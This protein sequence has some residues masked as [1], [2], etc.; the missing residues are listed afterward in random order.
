MVCRT[1]TS[2]DRQVHCKK[3]SPELEGMDIVASASHMNDLTKQFMSMHKNPSPV[4]VGSS[5]KF[6]L[7]RRFSLCEHEQALDNKRWCVHAR[8]RLQCRQGHKQVS[9]QSTQHERKERD[10]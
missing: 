9:A 4:Q 5:L 10:Y 3:Y 6:L 2:D 1:L 7:V 8:L